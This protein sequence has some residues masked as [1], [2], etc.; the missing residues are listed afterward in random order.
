MSMHIEFKHLRHFVA[1]AEELHFGRAAK[2]CNISQPAFSVSIQQLEQA[3][4]FSVVERN[5]QGVRL[6]SAGSFFYGEAEKTLAQ[7][8]QAVDVAVRVHEGMHGTLRVGFMA[9]MLPRWLDKA[10][11]TFEQ[12]CPKVELQLIE[13]S[14]AEQIVALQR[15]QIQY[16]FVHTT[17]LPEALNSQELLRERFVL[18]LP[19]EHPKAKLPCAVLSEFQNESFIIFA[20]AFS[21]T[22]YDQVISI[23]VEAGLHPRI[24]HEAR[25]W[26]TVMACVAR[27]IGISLVPAGLARTGLEGLRFLDIEE[28]PVK[29]IV[30]GAWL[31]DYEDDPIINLWRQVVQRVWEPDR[32]M[33]LP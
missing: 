33:S 28:S 4:G 10:V 25:H 6:T 20:R 29:S 30:R 31:R 12:Q 21:P 26:L 14:S 9:S 24:R 5:P 1:L 23:C 3:L 8:K 27:G 19:T 16:G 22:Y 18:C 15:S 11:Q 17:A 32:E 2:R 7:I 13:L